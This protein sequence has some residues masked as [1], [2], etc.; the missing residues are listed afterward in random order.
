MKGKNMN[1]KNFFY[2]YSHKNNIEIK[3]L[4]V[5]NLTDMS[6][7]FKFCYSLIS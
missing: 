3:L 7:M 6:S 2:F 5:N 4:G 1:Y